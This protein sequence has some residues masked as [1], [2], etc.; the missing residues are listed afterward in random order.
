MVRDN[1]RF[2]LFSK[3]ACVNVILFCTSMQ[4]HVPYGTQRNKTPSLEMSVF[5]RA[6]AQLSN[7]NA[8]TN[9]RTYHM[10]G[11][12]RTPFHVNRNSYCL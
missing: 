8:A 2:R 6:R 10:D 5:A 7:C 3:Y 4:Q 11:I 9:A 1:G 12:T